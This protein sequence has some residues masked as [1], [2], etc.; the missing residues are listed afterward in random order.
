MNMPNRQ[1]ITVSPDARVKLVNG[2][3]ADVAAGKYFREGV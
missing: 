1:N 3:F 2:R